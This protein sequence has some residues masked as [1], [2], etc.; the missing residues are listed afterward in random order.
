MNKVLLLFVFLISLISLNA[1]KKGTL[2]GLVY[3]MS[4]GYNNQVFTG[5]N[6]YNISHN[7]FSGLYIKSGFYIAKKFIFDFRYSKSSG[8][9]ND[10]FYINEQYTVLKHTSLYLGYVINP[11][12]RLFTNPYLLYDSINGRNQ[13]KFKGNAF[14]AGINTEF[15][16]FKHWFLD[17]GAEY[18]KIAFDITAPADIQDLFSK[19]TSFHFF[20]GLGVRFY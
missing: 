15:Y 4:I 1:Q 6:V 5:D 8:E 7:A 10:H 20:L 14:G 13:G 17:L 18:K 11:L 16:V 3:R 12:H 9:I 2:P 19:A